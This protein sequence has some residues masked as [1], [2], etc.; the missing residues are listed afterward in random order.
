MSFESIL[1]NEIKRDL[2]KNEY[3][4][5]FKERPHISKSV[6]DEFSDAL[7]IKNRELKVLE[8]SS[9]LSPRYV[10]ITNLT[11]DA[12]ISLYDVNTR[13]LLVYRFYITP[14]ELNYG[15]KKYVETF[16][17]SNANIEARIIGLQNNQDYYLLLNELSDFFTLNKIKLVEIDLFGT[18]I[19]HVAIDSKLGMSF[20]ILMNDRI[21][22]PGELVN[23]RTLENFEAELKK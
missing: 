1:K 7:Y 19:R 22:R 4:Q 3:R 2:N 15:L 14:T 13:R 16:K 9:E 23:S 8:Y 11:F 6:V 18:D 17:R 21:Y 12:I 10:A 5:S 20:N